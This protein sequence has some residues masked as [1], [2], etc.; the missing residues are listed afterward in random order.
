[1]RVCKHRQ[2]GSSG[3]S[4]ALGI[5]P[6]RCTFCRSFANPSATD[7]HTADTGVLPVLQ[8]FDSSE[9]SEIVEI[10]PPSNVLL[11]AQVQGGCGCK[12]KKDG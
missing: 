12:K 8:R 1:M 3:D 11:Q 5:K 7:R 4:C 6:M 9:K 2:S 10:P